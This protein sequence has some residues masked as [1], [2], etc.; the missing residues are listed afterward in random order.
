MYIDRVANAT[1]NLTLGDQVSTGSREYQTGI[2][3]I[4]AAG[5][6][7]TPTIK[8]Y[9]KLIQSDDAAVDSGWVELVS[10][11][12]TTSN[13]VAGGTIPIYPHMSCEVTNNATNSRTV[14]V[15]VGYNA[16]A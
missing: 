1:A 11:T 2:Y 12:V 8:I 14:N 16:R 4:E 5:T 15:V 3:S 6:T 9:G 10:L 7:S 13:E